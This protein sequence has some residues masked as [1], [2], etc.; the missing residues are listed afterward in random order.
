MRVGVVHPAM[1]SRGLP[2]LVSRQFAT[3]HWQLRSVPGYRG[4]GTRQHRTLSR[5]VSEPSFI[6][7]GHQEAA[8]AT[9]ATLFAD[10]SSSWRAD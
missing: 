2:M 9:F 8:A 1:I 10:G 4:L 3:E 5:A 6:D 7:Q